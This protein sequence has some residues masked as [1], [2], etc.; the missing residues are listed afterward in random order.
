M[1]RQRLS[2]LLVTVLSGRA[3][4]CTD[5][6]E[7]QRVTTTPDELVT[8][9]RAVSDVDMTIDWGDGTV[10][11]ITANDTGAQTHT[12]ATAGTYNI[13]LLDVSN[14]V[15]LR[16][17]NDSFTGDLSGW[18]LPDSLDTLYLH[19]NSFTGDLS[20]WTLPDSLSVMTLYNNNF[21]GDLSSWALPSSLS[22]IQIYNN[23]FTG[24]LSGWTLPG[25][26]SV[27]F[28][29]DNDFTL[30]AFA[31]GT[32]TGNLY[33]MENNAL[34]QAE[35]DAVL[36]WVYDNRASFGDATPSLNIGGTNAAPSGTYA[37]E[38]PPTTGNG[39]AYELVNDPETEGFN[40]WTI[41]RTT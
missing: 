8:V 28:L 3:P 12:Y 32:G 24:D 18:V 41:T 5:C 20:G 4:G 13:T 7:W 33:R 11:T 31:S 22:N 19:G 35:V 10:E 6:L 27:F 38:D 26:L 1:T 23:S 17:T 39:Y 29:Q 9:S 14:L 40:T 21:T 37:D 15:D 2:R 34:T 25:S 30:S 36:K 16:I